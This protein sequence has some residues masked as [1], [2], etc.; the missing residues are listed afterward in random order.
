[1]YM[2]IYAFTYEHKHTH[3]YILTFIWAHKL[4]IG[5]IKYTQV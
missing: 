3:N 5:L 2:Y 4:H 1:M